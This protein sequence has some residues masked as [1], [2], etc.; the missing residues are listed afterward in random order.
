MKRLLVFLFIVLL[1]CIT[2][3]TCVQDLTLSNIFPTASVEIYT[4]SKTNIEQL[5]KIE[6][7]LGEIIFCNVNE[8]DYILK[9]F[10][11]ISGFTLKFDTQNKTKQQILEQLN[12]QRFTSNGFGILGYSSTIGSLFNNKFCVNIDKNKCNFQLFETKN[13]IFLGVPIL[14]GSY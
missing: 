13:S 12:L 5:S 2:N 6:N 8:L 3:L 10:D 4:S 7:G 11:N 1:L 9:D 14:L